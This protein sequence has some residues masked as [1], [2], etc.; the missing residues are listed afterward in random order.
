MKPDSAGDNPSLSFARNFTN[1]FLTPKPVRNSVCKIPGLEAELAGDRTLPNNQSPEAK[2]SCCI[3]V[4]AVPLDIAAQLLA[5]KLGVIRG[6]FPAEVTAVG[7]EKAA[8]NF[9]HRVP[10]AKPQIGGTRQILS[11]QAKSESGAMK[12]A[13]DNQL[14]LCILRADRRHVAAALR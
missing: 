7:M 14:G 12:Q 1:G 6:R 5:P 10:F 8:L 4:A 13:P 9:D 2:G 11:V 3:G